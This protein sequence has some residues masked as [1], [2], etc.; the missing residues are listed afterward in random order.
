MSRKSAFIY[1][2]QFEKYPYPESCPFN[3]S[4][5]GKTRKVLKSMG[6][7]AGG[8]RVDVCQEQANEQILEIF[9]TRKYIDVLKKTSEGAFDIEALHMGLGTSD[10]P[11][12]K[13]MYENSAIACG[14]TVKGAEMIIQGQ[15]D[16]VF[17]PAGG[18]HHAHQERSS[19]FCYLNDVGIGCELLTKA[20]KRVLYLDVDVHHGDGVQDFFYYRDD[21]MTV[22][23][24]ESGKTLFPGTGFEDEIGSGSGKGY[25]V[26]VPLPVGTYDQEYMRVFKTVV[27]PLIEFY[28][29]D[30]IVFELG[31]DTLAG[32][33]L[34]RLY[35]TNNT[36]ADIINILLKYNKPILA[37]GGGGYNI[38]NTVRA[39]AF[40]WTV[41][42]GQDDGSDM[43][44]GM[45]GVMMESTDWQGGLRDR[46]L[47]ISG[48]QKN[49]VP[50]KI[51]ST[52]EAIRK[53]IFKLH[54][55]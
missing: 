41:L 30:V 46:E 33:P 49:S 6:M 32:D 28:E 45:G 18:L 36:Y 31:A 9:H 43:N 44:I 52:I 54:G 51:D 53:N 40:A 39:W 48:E 25:S 42:S 17:N 19:G 27:V 2:E 26:N 15:A 16:V 55:I 22:S 10:C 37:T 29:P 3:T 20:G 4:R 5:A 50:T 34:A 13:G 24:H 12:F 14:A 1:S 38:E 11:V 47:V 21:V 23:F 7:L 35:L 8:S